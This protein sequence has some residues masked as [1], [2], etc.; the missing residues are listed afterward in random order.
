LKTVDI[1]LRATG[2]APVMKKKIWKVDSFRTIGWI[3]EFIRRYIKLEANESLVG[4]LSLY[5]CLYR[6][7]FNSNI[8]QIKNFILIYLFF[9][10]IS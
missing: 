5:R 8:N 7:S 9:L 3:I 1:L 10:I 2:D 4:V 6:F